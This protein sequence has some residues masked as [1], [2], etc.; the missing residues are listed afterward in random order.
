MS[1]SESKV[2]FFE[3]NDEA[4]SALMCKILLWLILV[5]PALFLLHFNVNS[6]PQFAVFVKITTVFQDL[7][8]KNAAKRLRRETFRPDKT[9]FTAYDYSATTAMRIFATVSL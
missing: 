2:A 6:I 8:K 1:D 5:F 4:V 7:I 3:K 9:L